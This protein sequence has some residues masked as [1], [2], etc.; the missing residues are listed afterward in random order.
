MTARK[1]YASIVD[2]IFGAGTATFDV[3]EPR[4][5]NVIGAL[6]S[7]GQFGE[8][9]ANF[10]Q[11]LRRLAA[12]VK[13]DETLRSDIVAALQKIVSSEWDGAY[14]ELSAL[15]YFLADAATGPGNV[16]LDRTVPATDTLASDMGMQNANHDLH[17]PGLGVS[18]DTKLLSDKIGGILEGVFKDFRKA[19]GINSLTIL[20][21]FDR[22]QDFSIYQA[23][24]MKLLDELKQEVDVSAKPVRFISQVIPDL[25]Y[26]F[27][28]SAGVVFGESSYSPVEHAKNHHRLL[29]THAKK[30]SKQEP[31]VIVFVLFPWADEQVFYFEDT[32][33]IFCKEFGDQFFSGYLASGDPAKKFNSKFTSSISAGD[34]TKHLSGVLYLMD[35][36]IMAKTPNDL[37]I[38]ASYLWNP[39]ALHPLAGTPLE[40]SL[41]ARGAV[42]L[43]EFR[44][45][46]TRF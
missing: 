16:V 1:N 26:E 41:K 25:S 5:N 30:F 2:G 11:R 20:P 17:F 3:D 19:K 33:K 29:F 27:A 45:V 34:A 46:L 43:R 6:A 32:T 31:T 13:V 38:K 15:D 4:T 40:A 44:T 12:A 39:S 22:D 21:S 36:A 10:E 37:N 9:T 35:D 23:N 7:H 42:D 18:M 24:R 14:A 8:F 28:W